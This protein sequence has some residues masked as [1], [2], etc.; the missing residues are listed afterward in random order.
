MIRRRSESSETAVTSRCFVSAI[1]TN[2]SFLS[3]ARKMRARSE[4]V[5]TCPRAGKPLGFLKTVFRAP[6][7]RAFSFISFTNRSTSPAA[8]SA[9]ATDASLADLREKA[10]EEVLDGDPVP[11]METQARGRLPARRGRDR[12]FLSR[13]DLLQGQKPGHHLD[14]GGGGMKTIGRL[15]VERPTR[16]GVHHEG[17]LGRHGRRTGR[18]RRGGPAEDQARRERSREDSID[19]LHL[20]PVT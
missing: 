5:V 19:L 15:G 10:V 11:K 3:A 2:A 1:F 12:D 6:S 17:R 13:R 7:A 20:H 14:R 8:V 16:L 4:A 18:E 9:S